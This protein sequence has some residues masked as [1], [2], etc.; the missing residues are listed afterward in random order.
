[1]S[2]D[3]DLEQFRIAGS[4]LHPPLGKRKT[5]SKRGQQIG[6]FIRGPL[7]LAWFIRAANIPRRNALVVGM[8]LWHLAGLR[9]ER[10]GLVLCAQR[11]KP[12]GLG[13]KAVERGLR[14]LEVAGLIRVDRGAGRCPRV[15]VIGQGPWNTP[16]GNGEAG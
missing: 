3:V 10:A 7:P 2:R 16:G 8:V 14:D 11:C 12:F 9:S 1:M 5:S 13:R 4:G 15:D 6:A